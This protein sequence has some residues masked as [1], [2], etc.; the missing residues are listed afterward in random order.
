ML[1]AFA[2]KQK[3]FVTD[4]AQTVKINN[5]FY[6]DLYRI[7][8][9]GT[10]QI[11]ERE[12]IGDSS[13]Y[14]Q[15]QFAAYVMAS[16]K[17]A[18]T[19]YEASQTNKLNEKLRNLQRETFANTGYSITDSLKFIYASEYTGEWA[20]RAG[21]NG[22]LTVTEVTISQAANGNLRASGLP[23]AVGFITIRVESDRHF[24]LRNYPSTGV[25]TVMV[26]ENGRVF[27][28]AIPGVNVVFKKNN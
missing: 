18:S 15:H 6:K 11:P 16:R 21:Q 23:G 14:S 1:P 9:D 20:W 22:N 17:W 8:A 25:H 5:V 24:E 13:T 3:D 2:Q 10:G 4:T 12:L 26:S 27:R 19:A 7:R 28:N